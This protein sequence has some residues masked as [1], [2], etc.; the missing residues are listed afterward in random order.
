MSDNVL[1]YFGLQPITDEGIQAVIYGPSVPTTA[2][3]RLQQWLALLPPTIRKL[4]DDAGKQKRP[5]LPP[6]ATPEMMTAPNDKIS[7]MNQMEVLYRCIDLAIKARDFKMA[8][9]IA[10]TVDR[11][12][13]WSGTSKPLLQVVEFIKEKCPEVSIAPQIQVRKARLLKDEGD[14]HGAIQVLNQVL[15]RPQGNPGEWRYADEDQY[16][17]TKAEVI[18]IKG[19]IMHNLGMMKEAVEPLLQSIQLFASLGEPDDKGIA[20]CL[21]LLTRCIGKLSLNDYEQVRQRFPKDFESHHPCHQS[22][23]TGIEAVRYIQNIHESLYRSKHQLDA[24][25]SLLKYA[26][27]RPSVQEEYKLFQTVLKE[28]K[29]CLSAHKTISALRSLEQFHE[30]V[31]ALFMISLTL[32]LTPIQQDRDLAEY[33]QQL[34][35]ELYLHL[36]SHQVAGQAAQLD[37][38]SR[39]VKI[40]NLSL[41]I[42]DLPELEGKVEEKESMDRQQNGEKAKREDGF[43]KEKDGFLGGAS[44]QKGGI[45]QEGGGSQEGGKSQER[46]A[47]QGR[48]GSQGGG[49]S[50]KLGGD[51]AQELD[52]DRSLTKQ[53]MCSLERQHEWTEPEASHC[54]PNEAETIPPCLGRAETEPS[55]GSSFST[56]NPEDTDILR[57]TDESV[58]K[59]RRRKETPLKAWTY[60]FQQE[61]T[62]LGNEETTQ[63]CYTYPQMTPRR[64]GD[65]KKQWQ[66]YKH[67]CVGLPVDPAFFSSP[68]PCK[69]AQDLDEASSPPTGKDLLVNLSEPYVNQTIESRESTGQRKQITKEN[70]LVDQDATTKSSETSEY[71]H[72]V[73]LHPHDIPNQPMRSEDDR[74]KR[75]LNENTDV[76]ELQPLVDLSRTTLTD[77]LVEMDLGESITTDDP[78]EYLSNWRPPLPQPE[79]HADKLRRSFLLTYNPATGDWTAQSTLVYIGKKLD[80]AE[81]KRGHCRDAY[82]VQF[83]HQDEPRGRY[84]GKR[85]RSSRH[86]S[87]TRYMQDVVCQ[88]MAGHYVLKFNEALQNYKRDIQVQFLPA[89]HLQLLTPDGRLEDCINVEPYLHGDFIKLTNNLAF[90]NKRE[91]RG[92]ELATA[93]THFSFCESQGTLMIV[94]IQGWLGSEDSGVIY[95]TDPQFHTSGMEKFSPYDHQEKGMDKFWLEVHPVCNDMCKA[96]GLSRP[97]QSISE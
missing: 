43:Q 72:S 10:F 55:M 76:P 71:V 3:E 33:L 37:H 8:A 94:D 95:L 60:S 31:R 61:R 75:Q 4:I 84:V 13:Y 90:S 30:F 96:V 66:V 93:L 14:L 88:M 23:L 47:S 77:S 38:T 29:S 34:S 21:G 53:G 56:H 78:A 35:M 69:S 15:I 86:H 64:V 68:V 28:M 50:L 2:T 39:T 11:A 97:D 20:S 70:N 73:F 12:S 80:L 82:H 25:V 26:I 59:T 40:M 42:L 41:T 32:S 51:K 89:A 36:C 18:K 17:T 74:K 16:V 79:S 49:A 91:H 9:C 67:K 63:G 57:A 44:S 52:G 92:E 83:L 45:S 58:P 85:Y 1:K 87:V 62:S 6:D 46:G 22:Y 7:S 65:L 27:L 5:F 24:D 81:G 54:K 19:N 48:M